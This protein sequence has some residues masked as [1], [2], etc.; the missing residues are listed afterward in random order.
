MTFDLSLS[1]H[2]RRAS[3]FQNNSDFCVINGYVFTCYYIFCDHAI[4][5]AL[6]TCQFN[7]STIL[8]FVLLT[9]VLPNAGLSTPVGCRPQVCSSVV[10]RPQLCLSPCLGVALGVSR[11][12]LRV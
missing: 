5:I 6:T 1:V 4:V 8:R 11:R 10:L 3:P 12:P 9:N 2:R 7:D